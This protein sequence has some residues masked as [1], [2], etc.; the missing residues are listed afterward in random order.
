MPEYGEILNIIGETDE[1]FSFSKISDYNGFRGGH[2]ILKLLSHK[3][4]GMPVPR[5][6]D[7]LT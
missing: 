4:D 2:N 1:K 7:R 5:S 6:Y 3:T